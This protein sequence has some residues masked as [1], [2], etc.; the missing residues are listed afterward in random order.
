MLDGTDV[1]GVLM[2]DETDVRG[3]MLDESDAREGD[4]CQIMWFGN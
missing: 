1:S 4:G 3:V 2:L